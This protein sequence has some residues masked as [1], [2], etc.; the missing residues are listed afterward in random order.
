MSELPPSQDQPDDVDAS[1]RRA[2]ALDTSR[3]SEAVRRAVLTHATQLAA[4]YGAKGGGARFDVRW[5]PPAAN[6]SRWRPA[7]FGTLAAA[8][9]AGLLVVPHVLAPGGV[10]QTVAPAARSVTAPAVGPTARAVAPPAPLRPEPAPAAQSPTVPADEITAR[11]AA[12]P[13]AQAAAAASASASSAL[14][15]ARVAKARAARVAAPGPQNAVL[16]RASEPTGK[17]KAGVMEVVVTGARRTAKDDTMSSV[18]SITS[19]DS[20]GVD[21]ISSAGTL[22]LPVDPSEAFRQAA[23]TGDLHKMQEALGEQVDIN[24]RDDEGRTAL[25]RAALG[26]Q[27]KAVKLLLARGADPNLA[28]TNGLTPLQAATDGGRAEII[29][30]LKRAGA[31]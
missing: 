3:P 16:A 23:E 21:E 27:T 12:G 22:K 2:S 29:A 6:R 24:S 20:A 13:S 14:E 11:V 26:G 5:M 15:Q 17:D 8:A 10:R 1:Y 25:L 4:E 7:V 30:V 9:V 31:R 28:D 19:I 18:S